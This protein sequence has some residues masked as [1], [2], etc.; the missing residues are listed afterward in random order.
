MPQAAGGTGTGVGATGASVGGTANGVGATGGTG[1]GTGATGGTGVA[2]RGG[3]DIDTKPS[4]GG[5]AAHGGSAGS[6]GEAGRGA[7]AGS[8]GPSGTGGTAQPSG[9]GGSAQA[10]GTAGTGTG[11]EGGESSCAPGSYS[12]LGGWR[13]E[14][15]ESYAQGANYERVE[16]ATTI[17]QCLDA[18]DAREDCS[19]VSDYLQTQ[20]FLGC[21]LGYSSCDTL[22]KPIYAEEDGARTHRKICADDGSCHFEAIPGNYGCGSEAGWGNGYEVAGATSI[23]DCNAACLA[24]ST[25]QSVIDYFYLEA[26]P[27]CYL[28]TSTCDAPVE[29]FQDARVYVK[30]CR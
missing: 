14:N 15:T 9:T 4:A 26:V 16:G 13:C 8:P 29:T 20:V 1:S 12:V 3:I 10:G 30:D 18:C 24:S 21:Y 28:N 23:D 6:I 22:S 27:G 17:D 2:A 7:E 25:C 19:A 11:G 5:T